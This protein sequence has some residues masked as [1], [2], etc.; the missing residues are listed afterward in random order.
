MRAQIQGVIDDRLSAGRF[1]VGTAQVAAA[2]VRFEPECLVA[3]WNGVGLFPVGGSLLVLAARR[4]IGDEP[5]PLAKDDVPDHHDGCDSERGIG[6]ALRHRDR[7]SG[8]LG[9]VFWIIL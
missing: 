4:L 1:G 8:N 5:G 9:E 3:W 6:V 2:A 7:V